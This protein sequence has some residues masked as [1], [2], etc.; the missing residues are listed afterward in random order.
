MGYASRRLQPLRLQGALSHVDLG[1]EAMR[2]LHREGATEGYLQWVTTRTREIEGS[3]TD[4]LR[5]ALTM[6]GLFIGAQPD[7]GSR[8]R[9]HQAEDL[10]A[11]GVRG[12]HILELLRQAIRFYSR[13]DQGIF[14]LA[15]LTQTMLER[16]QFCRVPR[17]TETWFHADPAGIARSRAAQDLALR[18]ARGVNKE[19]RD[20]N[21]LDPWMLWKI[22]GDRQKASMGRIA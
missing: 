11:R 4:L 17:E 9:H 10:F 16:G 6:A 18:V 14:S 7:D 19:I 22:K 12:E 1:I 2:A 20:P 5:V 3:E 13:K 8:R 21:Q 15:M